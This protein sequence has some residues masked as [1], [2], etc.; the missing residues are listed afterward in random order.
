MEITITFAFRLKNLI[1][2]L[3]INKATKTVFG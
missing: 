3:F 2:Q 1:N